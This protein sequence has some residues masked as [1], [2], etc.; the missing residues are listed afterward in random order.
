L[1]LAKHYPGIPSFNADNFAY[2]P[3]HLIRQALSM[4]HEDKLHNLAQQAIPISIAA[5]ALLKSKGV[6]EVATDWFNPFQKAVDKARVRQILRKD[7]AKTFEELNK[8]GRLVPWLFHH[9]Q[10]YDQIK[11][12]LDL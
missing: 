1:T 9:R 10:V 5:T 2:T 6:K 8:E 12:I 7:A 3:L 4:I 11:L